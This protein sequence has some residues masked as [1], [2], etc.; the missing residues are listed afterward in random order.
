MAHVRWLS[1]VAPHC[2][3]Y[4]TARLSEH[5][6]WLLQTKASL[7]SLLQLCPRAGWEKFLLLDTKDFIAW[8][9]QQRTSIRNLATCFCRRVRD[10]HLQQKDKV[11]GWFR[12][13]TRLFAV[14]GGFGR[15]PCIEQHANVSCN[16][17]G[18]LFATKAACASHK[19][20]VHSIAGSFAGVFG[21]LC[22]ACCTEF[23][24]TQ[25]LRLHLRK[26]EACGS[27]VL[28]S[29]LVHTA[30]ELANE[31]GSEDMPAVRVSFAQPF[32]ATLRPKRAI[33][34]AYLGSSV[35]AEVQ[36][37]RHFSKCCNF[38][39]LLGMLVAISRQTPHAYCGA[40]FAMCALKFDLEECQAG[41]V[42]GL[43]SCADLHSQ[44]VFE[45]GG[46]KLRIGDTQFCYGPKDFPFLEL[47]LRLPTA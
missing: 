10:N 35:C 30:A 22:M 9:K 37:F 11:L 2:C 26:V 8:A 28:G 18:A 33:E 42:E 14:G 16:V 21:S 12:C 4:L 40:R 36:C 29:D 5:S 17:C 25:R 1:G 7:R 47:G 31:V 24:T 3:E 39:E 6:R 38:V 13:R 15:I 27:C 46:F 44:T 34:E 32:W 19:R 20:K 43:L 45:L 41:F 23:H